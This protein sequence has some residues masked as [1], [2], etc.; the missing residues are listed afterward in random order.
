MAR[1]RSGSTKYR[2]TAARWLGKNLW[3]PDGEAR[4]TQ[5]AIE[6]ALGLPEDTTIARMLCESSAGL[7]EVDYVQIVGKAYRTGAL[8][9]L[10]ILELGLGPLVEVALPASQIK[11]LLERRHAA[12][13]IF[14]KGVKRLQAGHFPLAKN[15]RPKKLS[16]A[17]TDAETW[18]IEIHSALVA[19]LE[20]IH[21]LGCRVMHRKTFSDWRIHICAA[22]HFDIDWLDDPDLIVNAGD[23][24]C[25]KALDELCL[26]KDGGGAY[27]EYVARALPVMN[28]VFD[29]ETG[30]FEGDLGY[31]LALV[32]GPTKW[33]GMGKAGSRRRKS[34]GVG[35]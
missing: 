26:V 25:L 3:M 29:E 5:A 1:P 7:D 28:V 30:V 34:G 22:G 2:K 17:G 35:L 8:S 14:S 23:I 33:W 4:G 9:R 13:E 27:T 11:V 21:E 6:A 20:E 10:F 24:L 31:P 12:F 19:W 15:G 18:I 16:N 32:P